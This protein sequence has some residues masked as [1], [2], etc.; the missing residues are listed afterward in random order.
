M[1]LGDRLRSVR[2]RRGLTQREL[3]AASRVSLSLIRKIEQGEI[4]QTRMETLRKLATAM[5]VPTTTLVAV[6][7]AEQPAPDM[8][9]RW[10][11]VRRALVE[12]PDLTGDEP[13]VEGISAVLA[14]LMPAFRSNRYAEC[15]AVLPG[16]IRDARAL[17][18]EARAVRA[19]IL[20]MAGTLLTHTHQYDT[21]EM[22]LERALDDAPDRFEASAVV[23]NLSWLMIRR[24]HIEECAR[25]ASR[26]AD[27]LEP[28]L[29]R[30]TLREIAAWGWMLLRIS[31][32]AVRDNR[33]GDALDAI[34]LA[35]SAAVAVGR[36]FQP[37]GDFLRPFGP[38][39]VTAKQAELAMI[40]DQPDRVLALA[41][42]IPADSI[43]PTSDNWN[44]H[45][46]DVANAHAR[47]GHT[48]DAIE[49]LAGIRSH[50]PE[51][52]TEQRYARD[53]VKSMISRRRTLTPQMRELA[54][55][56]R[57]EY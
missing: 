2:M 15:A 56:V 6:P 19:R 43:R 21:A 8:L 3:A 48:S 41:D 28:R 47:L 30:A 33:P 14:G 4:E 24:G 13:T 40:E 57:L 25:L 44:R 5:D 49:V 9:T 45:L 27:D 17:D 53:V 12:R 26:W 10:E 22:A 39:L 42:T 55:A 29:S 7:D 36:E 38:L 16:L 1:N 34:R 11:P 51:W 23:H 32:A 18:G 31:L 50:A 37:P 54:D 20:N 46:L 52:L 35:Q